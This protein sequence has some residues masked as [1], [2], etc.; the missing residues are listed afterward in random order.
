MDI[1]RANA[2]TKALSNETSQ[3]KPIIHFGKN[4]FELYFTLFMLLIDR[5]KT[6]TFL[7]GKG[8]AFVSDQDNPHINLKHQN[9]L[10]F[11]TLGQSMIK[12]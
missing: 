11:N 5:G 7:S 3:D 2:I 12:K 4:I 8:Y 10:I 9:S 1:K 6:W